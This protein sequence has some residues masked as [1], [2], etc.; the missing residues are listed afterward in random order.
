MNLAMTVGAAAVEEKNRGGRARS[1]RML[2]SHVT[3]SAE[4][5]IGHFE[6]SI[7]HRAVRFMA[8]GT[9]FH[10]RWMFPK[11]GAASFGVARVAILIDAVLLELSRARASVRIMTIRAGHLALSDRH[12]RR[13]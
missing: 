3:S 11:K 9:I 13:A 1:G 10:C 8:V 12:V 2:G 6:Q 7:V 4:S 5:R